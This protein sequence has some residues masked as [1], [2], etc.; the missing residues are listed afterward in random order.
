MLLLTFDPRFQKGARVYLHFGDIF[1]L[2]VCVCLLST[3]S[4]SGT[5]VQS[6]VSC[7]TGGL[8]FPSLFLSFN[9]YIFWGISPALWLASS[10]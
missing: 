4:L 2:C 6:L 8:H 1:Y 10:T 7:W 9:V 3:F 5:L